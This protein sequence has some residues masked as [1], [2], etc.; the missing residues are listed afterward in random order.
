MRPVSRSTKCGAPRPCVGAISVGVLL[1]AAP[2]HTSSAAPWKPPCSRM[3]WAGLRTTTTRFPSGDQ[4]GDEYIA[5]AD[6]SITGRP[7]AAETLYRCPPP[8]VQVTNAS[9]LPSGDHAGSAS[10]PARSLTR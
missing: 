1:P 9:D 2:T 6:V 10:L 4:T 7:P 8:F 3:V 5:L